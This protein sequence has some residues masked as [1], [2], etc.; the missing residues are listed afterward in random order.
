LSG[1][2]RWSWTLARWFTACASVLVTST[3]SAHAPLGPGDV[4]IVGVRAGSPDT[5][6]ALALVTLH[7]G[8]VIELTDAGLRDDVTFRPGEGASFFEVVRT[9]LPAGRVFEIPAGT[10]SLDR[11]S[12]QI[13]IYRGSLD[14]SGG[15][16]GAWVW[17][18]GWG[19]PF[20]AGATST[21][22][23]ALPWPLAPAFTELSAGAPDMAYVGP[24]A[25]AASVVRAAITDP[26]NWQVGPPGTLV[27]PTAFD[28]RIDRGGP[29]GMDGDCVVGDFCVD[30]TCCN[31]TCHRETAG[32]CFGCFFGTG[33]ARNGTCGPAT[34][35]QLCRVGH[36]I[37]DPQ[38]T[39]D[40][41]ST[42]CPP[43]AAAPPSTVCRPARDLCDAAEVC[44]GVSFTCPTDGLRAAGETCRSAAG[45]CDQL[46]ACDGASLSCPADLFVD[47]GAACASACGD[48]TCSAGVCGDCPDAGM[49]EI[50]AAIEVDAYVE[51]EDAGSDAGRPDATI[52]RRDAGPRDA[53]PSDAGRDAGSDASIVEMADAAVDPSPPPAGCACRAFAARTSSASPALALF[54]IALVVVARRRR[55]RATSRHR[56]SDAAV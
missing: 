13:F 29:C 16:V 45:S 55:G 38:E 26:A 56:G 25:G 23:S 41:V 24:T 34:T 46:E 42:A 48:A 15:L 18:L 40:G 10:M 2:R 12:D 6:I 27:F 9:T 50:D 54:T 36:G 49:P 22:D 39:C 53:A 44:D 31:S 51:D 32:L 8:D 47:D 11:S 5:L 17:A 52:I 4:A 30:A 43:N 19:T 20:G 21:S 14:A 1:V 3:A 37:C 28:V 35:S 7:E 33:D